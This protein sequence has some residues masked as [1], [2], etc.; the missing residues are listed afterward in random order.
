MAEDAK[1]TSVL[2][3]T[4][5]KIFDGV[6]EKLLEGKDVFIE[7]NKISKIGAD[8]KAPSG[9]RVIDAG[10]RTLTPGLIFMHE[11]MMYQ[12]SE[13]E[14]LLGDTRFSV[15]VGAKVARDYLANGITTVRDASGNTF[16]L[17]RAI[18]QGLAT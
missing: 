6:S 1:P 17:K 14:L 3:I 12:S 8:I 16:A 2:L 15:L 9:A 11:H 13:M 5:A 10:G 4:N 7:G 18:D